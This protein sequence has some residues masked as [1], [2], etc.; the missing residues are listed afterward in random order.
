MGPQVD[1]DY[2][3][4]VLWA[5]LSEAVKTAEQHHANKMPV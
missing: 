3:R 4:A 5:A 1:V 2:D